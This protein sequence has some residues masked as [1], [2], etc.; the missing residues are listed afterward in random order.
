M[1][2]VAHPLHEKEYVQQVDAEE[3][4]LQPSDVGRWECSVPHLAVR[5]DV[6]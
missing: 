3:T 1:V 6:Q 5:L 4:A 2:K